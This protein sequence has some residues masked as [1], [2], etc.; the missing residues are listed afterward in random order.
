MKTTPTS[1]PWHVGEHK[2]G[3]IQILHSDNSP[4]AISSPLAKVVNRKT[5]SF[6][7]EA[8]AHLI[9]AAPELYEA[10]ARALNYIGNTESELGIKLECG[11]L[12]RAA[13]AKADGESS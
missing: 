9:S 12:L 8:N 4:G 6:E 10:A 1:G 13:L 11:D 3:I 7:A 2:D 5:W